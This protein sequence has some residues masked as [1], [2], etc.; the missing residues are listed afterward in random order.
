[1]TPSRS[2]SDSQL[3]IELERQVRAPPL[4]A[5][6]PT[7]PAGVQVKQPPSAPQLRIP[8]PPVPTVT[9]PRLV[10]STPTRSLTPAAP[11][12][13]AAPLAAVAANDNDDDPNVPYYLRQSA[14]AA[15]HLEQLQSRVAATKYLRETSLKKRQ[16]EAAVKRPRDSD[17]NNVVPAQSAP[18]A[19]AVEPTYEDLVK[20]YFAQQYSVTQ[21]QVFIEENQLR[22]DGAGNVIV[23]SPATAEQERQRQERIRLRTLRV[24]QG[25]ATDHMERLTAAK[26]QNAERLLRRKQER[27][28]IALTR[29]AQLIAKKRREGDLKDT[30][31]AEV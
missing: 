17:T 28:A 2:E 16:C 5:L 4:R 25:L 23:A 19:P 31:T 21:R 8:P 14:H 6:N 24:A 9:P 1:M 3:A 12:A 7:I 26:R 10:S 27:E 22:L 13:P 20:V 30:R 18:I 29:L 15:L 11:A